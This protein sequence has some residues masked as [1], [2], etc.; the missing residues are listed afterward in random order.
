V[1]L[2]ISNRNESRPRENLEACHGGYVDPVRV[3]VIYE[4]SLTPKTGRSGTI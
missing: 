1:R 3:L 2:S 4:Y